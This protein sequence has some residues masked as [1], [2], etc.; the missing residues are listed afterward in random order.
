MH[1]V[2]RESTE[3]E[4]SGS[5]FIKRELDGEVALRNT[6]MVNDV[7][8]VVFEVLSRPTKLAHVVLVDLADIALVHRAG[9][10]GTDTAAPCQA[11]Q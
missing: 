4:L 3:Y 8:V 10:A 9:T 11:C 5:A 6:P 7:G 1:A 2:L